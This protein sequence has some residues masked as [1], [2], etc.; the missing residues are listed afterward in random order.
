MPNDLVTLKALSAE[1]F[2]YFLQCTKS[3][4]TFDEL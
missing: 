1:Q 4:D 2:G 3:K